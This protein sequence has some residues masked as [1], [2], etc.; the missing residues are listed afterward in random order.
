VWKRRYTPGA[1]FCPP[2]PLRARTRAIIPLRWRNDRA[3]GAR[4][5]QGMPRPPEPRTARAAVLPMRFPSTDKIHRTSRNPL[6]CKGSNAM[7]ALFDHQRVS[8]PMQLDRSRNDLVTTAGDRGRQVT[9]ARSAT[10]MFGVHRRALKS[11]PPVLHRCVDRSPDP[12]LSD[13]RHAAQVLAARYPAPCLRRALPKRGAKRI[14][15][16]WGVEHTGVGR[17]LE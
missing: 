16:V 5:R 2:P 13:F 14:R 10:E 1:G 3:R 15:G 17:G 4:R 8:V 11:S 9:Q 6:R 7:G 12:F